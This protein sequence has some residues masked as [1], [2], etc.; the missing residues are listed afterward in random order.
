L[1]TR[2][3]DPISVYPSSPTQEQNFADVTRRVDI[4]QRA[5][6]LISSG[7]ELEPLLEKILDS[8]VTLIQ[9][10][11]GTIG[12]VV[13]RNHGPVIK[14]VAVFNM[15]ADELGAEMSPGVGL[16][17]SV[18][19]DGQAILLRRYGDLEQPTLP[20]LAEHSVIGVPIRWR[21]EMIGFF[22]IGAEAPHRFNEQDLETLEIFAQYAAVAIHNAHLFEDS[23]NALDEMRLLYETS[24]RIGLGRDV[25]EVITAYLE[26]VARRTHYVC[27]VCLYEF[28]AEG[29]RT[30]VVIR[31]RWNPDSGLQ[32]LEERVPYSRDALDPLL[33]AGQTVTIADVRRDPRISEEL[34]QMQEASGRLALAL[35]PL[36]VRGRRIG[37]VV[38]SH[39]QVYEWS[40]A[41]LRS[42][43][44][45]AAQ[46]AIAIDSRMQQKLLYERGR[47]LAVLQE[48]ERLAR[49]L[50][51][52]VTQ[53]IFSTTL[54]A[55]SIAPAWK[56]DP[57][58]GQRRVDRLLE[59]S[60]T[61]LREMRSL[62][63]E[64]RPAEGTLSPTLTG[65]ER[66]S[67]Y[68]LLEALHL[69]AG[70]FSQDGVEVGVRTYEYSPRRFQA[71][72]DVGSGNEMTIEQDVYR[73]VQE[74][75][76]NAIKHAQ[77]H[78]ILVLLD[79][80]E[81]GQLCL[82]ISDD[83]VGFVPGPG[84]ESQEGGFGMKTM[85]ER[86][87]TLGGSL[88][89]ISAPG[90]GTTIEVIVPISELKP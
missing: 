70:D 82:S 7:L 63:F 83:G 32:L 36:M 41:G 6:A 5:M 2:K 27:N 16:A 89:V 45:T 55:Q 33:D 52:S 61:A 77:A 48:R 64:L 49:E 72:A 25:D 65:P 37:L 29:G 75:L 34:R 40:E 88:R 54:I 14:T 78:E 23:R 31:G 1:A 57:L 3:T 74:A 28:D 10:T 18:L 35:I 60:Q 62:L 26:Q 69:L 4:L 24:Q 15:P 79:G 66:V 59:L 39:P 20:E 56:R 17:G 9:A 85:S 87:E 51:D 73:I 76:N 58:E 42:Y 30:A 11:H 71:G 67:R 50:H 86:A 46:L 12:L 44:A 90:N 84:E 81:P 19:R 53:L 13:Q 8:A 68:G 80:S 47:Q 21:G 22:G 38:L 43:H